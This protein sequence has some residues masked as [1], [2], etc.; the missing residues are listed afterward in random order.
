MR[1]DVSVLSGATWASI[2]PEKRIPRNKIKINIKLLA[3]P[4]PRNFPIP[5][6]D[7]NTLGIGKYQSLPP[8]APKIPPGFKSLRDEADDNHVEYTDT[9]R[10]D[11]YDTSFTDRDDSIENMKATKNKND[12]DKYKEDN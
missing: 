9:S 1:T 5:N 7:K 3:T 4:P 10:T 2:T 6:Q 12:D 11:R 8:H